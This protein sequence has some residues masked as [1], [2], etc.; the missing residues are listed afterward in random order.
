MGTRD[1]S[2]DDVRC[3]R[4]IYN[5]G[6]RRAADI[7]HPPHWCMALS[8]SQIIILGREPIYLLARRVP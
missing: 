3:F 5:P 8:V 7:G 6:Q 4:G 1:Q 2:T